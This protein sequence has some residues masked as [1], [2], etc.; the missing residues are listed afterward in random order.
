VAEDDGHCGPE[1]WGFAASQQP[2][3]S[4]GENARQNSDGR[5]ASA[6]ARGEENVRVIVSGLLE[7][8]IQALACLKPG[9]LSP[10][11]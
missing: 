11:P 10:E 7:P 6:A 9:K 5:W 8:L 2:Q 1:Q 4:A 3:Q